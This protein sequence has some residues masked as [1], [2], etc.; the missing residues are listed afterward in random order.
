MI[1]AVCHDSMFLQTM[2]SPLKSVRF[3]AGNHAQLG[4]DYQKPDKNSK[5][6]DLYVKIAPKSSSVYGRGFNAYANYIH[7][8]NFAF[9]SGIAYTVG[10]GFF[11]ITAQPAFTGSWEHNLWKALTI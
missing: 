8:W 10:Y 5:Y 7:N 9:L 3:N 1:A 11:A 4:A 2:E 6:N